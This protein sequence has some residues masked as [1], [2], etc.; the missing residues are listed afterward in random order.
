MLLLT[1]YK[2][3]EE[4]RKKKKKRHWPRVQKRLKQQIKAE[5]PNP[6]SARVAPKNFSEVRRERKVRNEVK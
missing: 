5:K 6:L 2:K 1:F 4:K 3:E